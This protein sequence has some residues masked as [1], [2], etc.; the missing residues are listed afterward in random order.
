VKINNLHITAFGK[1][2]DLTLTLK[3]GMNLIEG[4]N[5]FGKSTIL[6]FIRA[7][8]YGFSQRS[9]TRMRDN[10][11][12]KFTP[13]NGNSFG[14]S[15]EFEHEGKTYLL[16][17][18]FLKRRADD[19]TALTLL[20]SGQKLDLAQKDVGEYLF[21]IS[22]AEFV[23]TVFVGQLSSNI[24]NTEKE[25]DDI[26][27]RLANLAGTGS[28]L[29]SHE[30]IKARLTGAASKLAALRGQGGLIPR[31]EDEL[32]DLEEKEREIDESEGQTDILQTEI[33][34]GRDRQ[35]AI[36]EEIV[37]VSGQLEE[38]QKQRDSLIGDHQRQEIL[39][40]TAL[41]KERI[42]KAQTSAKAE[43]DRA[44]KD[45][46][47]R[48]AAMR[49]QLADECIRTEEEI[50][51]LNQQNADEVEHAALMESQLDTLLKSQESL[52]EQNRAL[53]DM[54]VQETKTLEEDIIFISTDLKALIQQREAIRKGLTTFIIYKM[55]ARRYMILFLVVFIVNMIVYFVSRDKVMLAGF[56]FLILAGGFFFA[57]LFQRKAIEKKIVA[58]SLIHETKLKVFEKASAAQYDGLTDL[59]DSQKRRDELIQQKLR[60]Q[61]NRQKDEQFRTRVIAIAGER[62]AA[63]RMRITDFD[64]AFSEKT[65]AFAVPGNDIILPASP[66]ASP[67]DETV[68]IQALQKKM[69]EEER[70][71]SVTRD[72]ASYLLLRLEKLSTDYAGS[73]A[74]VVRKETIRE[75]L[76]S[77]A[78]DRSWIME[79]RSLLTERLEQAKAYHRALLTAQKVLDEA[80]SEMENFF[81]PQ[82]NEKA[83]EYF[84][85]L[86]EGTYSTLHV[87]RSFSVDIASVGSYSFHKADFFSGGTVD[88]IYFSLRLAITDLIQ[89]SEDTMPLLLDDAFVQ[90]D[91]KRAKAGLA[92]LSELSLSRQILLFTCHSRMRELHE[93]NQKDRSQPEG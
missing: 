15:I 38:K 91:D 29:F 21:A 8:F 41:Q 57:N 13:W 65:S 14:G 68:D 77:Q 37:H 54:K 78:T 90:Y 63:C 50:V 26:S 5:E 2:E 11:R 30:E 72:E 80:F 32:A 58:Q 85:K 56:I 47:Q 82:V 69:T 66:D 62:L 60:I 55:Q 39:L 18:V 36:R 20:P 71:I 48:R 1:L 9:Q 3:P 28:E 93:A 12:R 83:G 44:H 46:L 84:E 6:S 25:T 53:Q 52:C 81:A 7:M 70:Q 16:E 33:T 19:R 40:Q 24:L 22:E 89:K 35:K 31:I 61:E 34:V 73:S 45:Q 76:L 86:T 27:S 75:N 42:Q 64:A 74:N 51:R 4:D 10:D 43:F 88:Q 67:D 17:K 49:K 79:Q 59:Q 92:L 87:D 23:N